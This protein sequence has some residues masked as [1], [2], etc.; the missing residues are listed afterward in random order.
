MLSNSLI[1][2]ALASTYVMVLVLHLNPTLPLDPAELL[3]LALTIGVFYAVHLTAIGYAVLVVRQLA[4]RELFSPAWVS[5]GV[6]ASLGAIAAAAGAAIMWANAQTFAVVLRESTMSALVASSG[7][8]ACAAVLFATVALVRQHGPRLVWA[9]AL[10][11]IGGASTAVPVALRGQGALPPLD[12]HP[13]NTPLD[14]PAGEHRGRVTVVAIDAASL[15]LIASATSEGRL[16]NFGRMLDSGAVMH[17]ATLHPTSAE[18]VWAAVA[19]GKLPQKNGVRSAAVYHLSGQ[20]RDE[21]LQ[22]LPDFCFA[23]GLIRFGIL[24]GEPRTSASLRTRPVWTILSAAGIDV[25]VVNWPVTYPAPAVRGFVISDQYARLAETPSGLDDANTLYPPEAQVSALTAARS[26]DDESGAIALVTAPLDDRYKAA[27]R[28]DRLY[29][30]LYRTLSQDY[31]ADVSFVRYQS[32]DPIGHYFLRY[33][34]PGTFGDVTEEER[35]R[36]GGVLEAHYAVI[37]EA[38]GRLLDALGPDDLLLVVSGFGIEPLGF[39]K[40]VLERVIGDPDL[41]GTHEGAPDGFLLA[42]GA[43]VAKARQLRRGSVVDVVPTL[44][45]F[46]G[47][48]V[49]RDM[50][51][52]ARTDLFQ[53]SFTGERPITFIPTYDR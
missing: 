27:A 30:R 1:V 6:I 18:A 44:L 37:D 40:R 28:T 49:G 43:G 19:T 51:G 46:L 47:L 42:Y 35:L 29:D 52:Y 4:G 53:P 24:S 16:P 48:P 45:Y 38:L 11:L 23:E 9:V 21:P 26:T 14:V 13:L 50:D 5:I 39:G 33:A 25:G 2:G 36:F 22:L 32:L 10:L 17:L 8:L 31:E 34:M 12:S 15:E 20:R 7:V 41:S 3:S